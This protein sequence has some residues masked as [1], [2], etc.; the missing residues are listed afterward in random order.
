MRHYD[1]CVAGDRHHRMSLIDVALP[2]VAAWVGVHVGDDPKSLCP[3]ILPERR[4]PHRVKRDCTG[5]ERLRIKVVI[6]EV[7]CDARGPGSLATEQK[8][9]G[10][11]L[12]RTTA[13]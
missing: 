10:F 2:D 12:A 5:L 8:G 4:V 13:T 1:G 6:T 11:A 3:A 7:R 9:T